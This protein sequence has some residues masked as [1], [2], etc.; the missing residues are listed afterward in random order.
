MSALLRRITAAIV[1]SSLATTSFSTAASPPILLDWG[2]IDT[3]A[4]EFQAG[5]RALRTTSRPVPQQQLSSQGTAPWLVQFNDVIQEEWKTAMEQAGATLMGYIPENAFLIKATPAALSTIS[6]LPDVAWVGEYLPAYKH[7]RPVRALLAAGTEELRDYNVVLFNP[8][9]VEAMRAEIAAAPGTVILR[10]EPMT[11][12]GL[13]RATLSAS[14]VADL[15]TRAEVEWIEPYLKPQKWNDVAV[16]GNKMNVT[17][18]WF[19]LGITGAG[20]TIAICDTGLDT[21]NTN[22]LHRDFTNRVRG[23]GWRNGAF[24]AANSWSD[25]D[26]H[27]T[28]VAGSVAG[29]GVSSTGRYR[30]VAYQANLIFQGAGADLGGIPTDLNNLFRQA[31]TNGARI[32]SDSWGYDDNGYYNTD[33]RS[34]DMFVWSNK[35]M[36]ILVA[37]GNQ[38]IDANSDGVIDLDSIGSPAT[39]KNCLSIGA[40]ENYRTTGGYST[41]RYGIDLW[42]SD[43]PAEP[44]RSDLVSSPDSPQGMAAFSS[45]GPCDDGRIK[46]DL[47][48]PGTDIIST[49]SKASTDT[50]WGTVTG[51]TNYMFM[52][53][54]SM[55]TPLMAGAAGL[56]RQWIITSAGITNPSAALVKAL[57]MNG[58]RNMAPG[59]YGTGSTQE[60]PNNRPNNVQGWGHV[61]LY[62]TLKPSTNLALSL[63]DT[64]SLSTGQSNQFPFVISAATT[65]KFSITM[66]YSDY[67]ATAGSSKRLIND[68]DLTLVKPSGTVV[69]PNGNNTF[70]ATNNVETIDFT[71][72]ET[73]T[74]IVRV[75][76]RTVPSGGTQAYALVVLAP[77]DDTPTP[78]AFAANP[79]PFSTTTGVAVA[80]TVSASGN[81]I[82]TLALPATT[83]TSGYTFT[84]GTGL[85]SYTPPPGDTGAISFT[86]TASNTLAIATQVVIVAVDPT[87][88]NK[89]PVIDPIPNQTV[90]A[91]KTLS[92]NVVASDPVDGDPFTLSSA[93]LPP[94]ATFDTGSG[95]F[96]WTDAGPVGVYTSSFF[97]TD[98]HGTATQVVLITCI[99]NQPPVLTPV[100]NQSVFVSNNLFLAVSAT[101]PIGNDT[102]TLTASNLPAGATFGATNGSGTLTWLNASPT[103]AYTVT[104]HASDIAGT[105]SETITIAV[106]DPPAFVT[107]AET[108]DTNSFWGGGAAGSYNAK[109]FTNN[110]A[111]PA[112][113]SFE[114]NAAIRDTTDVISGN[115]WRIGNDAAANLYVRYILTN[116]VTRFSMNLARWDNSPTPQF[117]IRYSTD[118]GSTYTTLLAT[119]GSWFTADRTYKLYDSGPLN[120]APASGQ[121]IYIELFRSTGERMLLDNFEVD[122]IPSGGALP[123]TPPTLNPIGNKAVTLSNTLAF[124]VTATPTDGDPVTLSVSNLP[125]GA[126]FGATNAV[127]TFT[128]PAAAP[129]G[130]YTS[131]F[132]A[133]DNDGQVSESVVIVVAEPITGCVAFI[134]YTNASAI[135]LVDNAPA[136]PYPSTISVAGFTQNL[137]KVTV[138]L[139]GLSHDYVSDLDALLVGPGG[140]TVLLL[141]GAA[142]GGVATDA[143]L[144]FDATAPAPLPATNATVSSGTYQ[145]SVYLVSDLDAPAPS[146]PYTNTLGHF[147]GTS[148]NGTWSLYLRDWEDEDAGLIARGWSIQ[149]T[150]ACGGGGGGGSGTSVTVFAE[151]IGSTGANGD[152]IATHEANNRFDND[153]YTM[154]GTGD[155]RNTSTSSGYPGSSGVNN[156]ML[157]ALGEFF[158]IAGIN[159]AN[160][161]NLT[162]TFG[163]R[164]NTTTE[165]GTNLIVEVSTNG[166]SWTRISPVTAWLPT[167]TG[168]ATWYL[169]TNAIP[170]SLAATGM[171]LRFRSTNTVEWRIDD[172]ILA[173]FTAG[174]EPASA[175]ELVITT[176]NQTVVFA[177]SNLAVG[178]TSANLAGQITWANNLGGSGAIAAAPAWLIPSVPLAVGTNTVTVTGSNS[179]GSATSAVV[180]ITRESNDTDGDGIDDA[181]EM[182]FF[183]S[184]T[185]ANAFTDSDNDGF[186]DLHE[187]LAGTVPTNASSLLMVD[188]GAVSGPGGMVIQWPG[189]SGRSYLL[190]QTTN[191]QQGVFVPVASNIPGVEP[192][193]TYTSPA[194]PAGSTIYR[195]E[196][197]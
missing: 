187:F 131:T 164:K 38:G 63:Y 181:W 186:V 43:Y 196:L 173:G 128:W 92:F 197:E 18:V 11:D 49:R 167:G 71:P 68:L 4:P 138:T 135:T 101:D 134:A 88:S 69:Y 166:T 163:V 127:G 97:A 54:T 80:F 149:L 195:I 120:L 169:R 122:F 168:T 158:Q 93:N 6:R 145:P 75:R 179:T 44:I 190:S 55:A 185:N 178:G 156:V 121:R 96:L 165:N 124:A 34:L 2:T 132:Y 189:V 114:S 108:F 25:T 67:F 94:L 143:T 155:I 154:T 160:L 184:L 3:S 161:T 14:V 125:A 81:P 100:G 76:G 50:G 180:V 106:E 99:S 84:P 65:N 159:S 116:P 102:I 141:A 144:T 78:P 170:D 40:A 130:T 70:D 7:A 118:S 126:T 8:S 29:S 139:D 37:A 21:G 136:S 90:V 91:G 12:R 115:A 64:N 89:P 62:N 30:G 150:F 9:D 15:A 162:V 137:Q 56:T 152:S 52:G 142:V 73:G 104:L 171:L 41:R 191:L 98:I 10:A 193:V 39:A 23:F 59:Q 5:A 151:T 192:T 147:I 153:D 175:P 28:H 148:P 123:Q 36:L 157:N 182:Y 109:S 57:M 19:D 113:D 83:A 46:P 45:R 66:A 32:H 42:P 26:G 188:G 48:A 24:S 105:S 16:R 194:S 177:V 111:L 107:Y 13:I 58:A 140:Q 176:I 129:I 35:T 146:G 33:S 86:F 95:A 22:T 183:G 27:G 82:P 17:N 60:I 110:T 53:G 174:A 103:G 133:A 87:P 117:S 119:N 31:F 72:D 172:I 20:Q 61:D 77:R 51:N 112:G 74:Y 79:G 1:L 47:V 85:L